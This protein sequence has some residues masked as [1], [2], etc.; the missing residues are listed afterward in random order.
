M[1]HKQALLICNKL[2]LIEASFVANLHSAGIHISSLI[3]RLLDGLTR[4]VAS[5]VGVETSVVHVT[6]FIRYKREPQGSRKEREKASYYS[7][8]LLAFL[9]SRGGSRKVPVKKFHCL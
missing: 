1:L 6:K 4:F 9:H 7:V 8:L 5:P 2:V 3:V